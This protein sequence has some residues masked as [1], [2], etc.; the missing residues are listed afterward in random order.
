MNP[1]V[2]AVEHQISTRERWE[3]P[4]VE[5]ELAGGEVLQ[6]TGGEDDSDGL[7]DIPGVQAVAE[8]VYF[9][10]ESPEIEENMSKKRRSQP[11]GAAV[12]QTRY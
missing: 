2:P 11:S 1:V 9:R 4:T 7:E 8:N 3:L 5:R 12:G 10:L 6:A